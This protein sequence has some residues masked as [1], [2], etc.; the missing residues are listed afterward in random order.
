MTA[1]GNVPTPF[2]TPILAVVVAAI[3]Q[4]TNTTSGRAACEQQQRQAHGPGR[5]ALRAGRQGA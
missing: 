3:G 2:P 1:L 4:D 5:S